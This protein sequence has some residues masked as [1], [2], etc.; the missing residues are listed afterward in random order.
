[1]IPLQITTLGARQPRVINSLR[2]SEVY[3]RKSYIKPRGVRVY[4]FQAHLGG[5]GLFEK[6]E[7]M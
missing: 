2:L 5:G 1:M 7:L 3:H 4:L 6:E